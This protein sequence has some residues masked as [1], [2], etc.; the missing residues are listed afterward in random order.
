MSYE[1]DLDD[2]LNILV[3]DEENN[4]DI[5]SFEG[6]FLVASN[7]LTTGEFHQAIVYIVEHDNKGA[8]GLILNKYIGYNWLSDQKVIEDPILDYLKTQ[9]RPLMYGGPV[10]DKQI[11]ILALTQQQ[12]EEFEQEKCLT[13]YTGIQEFIHDFKNSEI[14][15]KYVVAKGLAVWGPNQLEEEIASN[16]WFI[17]DAT[18]GLLFSSRIANKWAEAIC[19]IGITD[20]D[21]MVPYIGHA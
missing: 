15:D 14:S 8:M 5:P 7:L 2:I 20:V 18:L 11:T 10:Q 12:E 17:T 19:N 13:I 6:R 4:D 1:V 16:A 9:R 3:P 21:K